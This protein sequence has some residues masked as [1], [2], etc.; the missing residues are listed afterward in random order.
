MVFYFR[1]VE[2]GALKD[3]FVLW[4]KLITDTLLLG[5]KSVIKNGSGM[6]LTTVGITQKYDFDR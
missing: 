6:L 5:I 3:M 1:H 2:I 4:R